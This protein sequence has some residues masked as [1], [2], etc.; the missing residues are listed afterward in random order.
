[1]VRLSVS[2]SPSACAT[3]NCTASRCARLSEAEVEQL[4]A[5]PRQ[6]GVRGLQIAMHDVMTMGVLERVGDL[7]GAA[8]AVIR[9]DQPQM[10]L[11]DRAPILRCELGEPCSTERDYKRE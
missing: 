1:M 11:H 9:R 7:D 10:A 2:G 5:H 8:E 3:P 4:G 6:H